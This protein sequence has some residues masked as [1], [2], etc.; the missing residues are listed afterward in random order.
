MRILTRYILREVLS[1][2]LIG[3]AIFTF[4][5][6]MR[7]LARILEIVV[8]NSAP[9]PSVAELFFLTLPTAL[10]LTLPMAV[11]VGI[12]IGLSRLAAD[13]EVTAMRAIGLGS[14]T[15][16]RV[17]A[18][19]AIAAWALALVNN[20]Y[21]AP[22]SAAALSDLQ[23]RLKTSQA[24]FEIQPR[25]FYEDFKDY[26]LYV[27]DVTA[28]SGAALW[29]GVFLADLSNPSSPKIT[30][31]REGIVTS[32]G[33]TNLRL[34]LTDGSSHETV[35]K[36]P[37]QYS[38]STFDHSDIPIRLPASTAPKN[39]ITPAAEVPTSQLLTAART[40]D[41]QHARL[42]E[43]EF[44]R[45]FALPTACL[46]LALV[47]IPLGLSAKKGGKST[48]FVL[49]IALVFGYY[50]ISLTGMSLAR[51]G[52]LPVGPAMWLGNIVFFV[53]GVIL[54][55]RVD[56]MPIEIGSL[57]GFWSNVRSK[58]ANG[59]E[60]LTPKSHGGAFERALSRKRVF[61]TRFP[62]LIDDYILRDFFVYLGMIVGT[63]I[64]LLLV[65]TFF[66][67][68]KDISRVP[69]FIVGEYL[70]TVTPYFLYNITPIG[71]LLAVLITFGLFEKSSEIT[72]M[73]ASG[74]SIYRIILPV[75]VMAAIVAAGMFFFDQFYLPQLNKKQDALR[76]QI[77]G[78]P[79][80]TYLRPDRKWIFGQHSTIY[81]YEFFDPD[82]NRFGSVSAF[83]F[84][85]HT[86]QLKRRIYAERA[87]WSDT[88][89]RWIFENGWERDFSG[90]NVT[91]F[92]TF[93]VST[94]AELS[95]SPMYFKKEVKQSL[96]MNYE[97]LRKYI[98]DLAQSGFDVV[99]LK[100]Q[101]HKKFAFPAMTFV[102]AV[103]AVPF[104]LRGGRRGALTGIAMAVGIAVI[105]WIG[106]G[107]FEAMGDA[108]QLPPL[109]AAWFPD[110]LFGLAGGYLL[111]KVPT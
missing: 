67:L 63:F 20:V 89:Q 95:E 62:L 21:I 65:F 72:A 11:L 100:V 14:G 39:E 104:A 10:T 40:L 94:F 33:S 32:E 2:A 49:T 59:T 58:F 70:V 75:L 93:E 12:L 16:L 28:G 36:D 88:L 86:F 74:M 110:L 106:M 87:H 37:E 66:E 5:I 96:E 42:Y 50:L 43:I 92:R 83:E 27:Q 99:R 15:F 35:P 26:V 54:L 53:A 107:F 48:G 81:Y 98:N 25:V 51:Q 56:R 85:P 34:H 31:A 91:D 108:N 41:R 68:L 77:K 3:A 7:D 1:H 18:I 78:K 45:R 9:L 90:S 19:F 111:L 29:K 8:R 57:R 97:E 79:P 46:V 60:V 101:L 47:G 38:I 44:H 103:L 109:L 22:K 69:L 6:F 61:S 4:V 73:K 84:D 76:N 55:W 13:S 71:M 17:I 23:D 24:S 30:V 64:V 102:M 80:Q 82:Q 52:K 105:Y